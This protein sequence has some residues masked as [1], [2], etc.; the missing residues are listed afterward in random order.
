MARTLPPEQPCTHGPGCPC[1]EVTRNIRRQVGESEELLDVQQRAKLS[2]F[3]RRLL[4][5]L[6]EIRDALV[7]R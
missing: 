5:V 6:G 7:R 1:I 4:D 2:Q 3:E